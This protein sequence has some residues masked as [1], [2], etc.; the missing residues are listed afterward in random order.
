MLRDVFYIIKKVSKPADF[1]EV[2]KLIN[3]IFNENRHTLEELRNVFFEIEDRKYLYSPVKYGCRGTGTK[4][5]L[6]RLL[7]TAM[8]AKLIPDAVF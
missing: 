1:S 4:K 8:F 3:V 2:I 5:G 6:F 7:G